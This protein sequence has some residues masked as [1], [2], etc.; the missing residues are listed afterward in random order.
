MTIPATQLARLTLGKTAATVAFRWIPFFLPTL[1]AAFDSSTAELTLILGLGEMGALVSLLAGRFFDRG[2]ERPIMCGGLT[3]TACSSAV[4]LG[5]SVTTFVVAFAMLIIGLSLYT[6]GG[7]T[8][9][10][11]RTPFD[12]RGRAIGLFETSWALALLLGAPIM[13]LLITR[14][15]W[16][17]PFVAIGLVAAVMVVVVTTTP[18]TAVVQPITGPT[19]STQRLSAATWRVI[20]ASAAI[21]I[22]GMSLIVVIGTWLDEALGVSTGGVGLAAMAFGAVELSSSLGS[23]ASSDRLGKTR[24]TRAMVL[25][26]LIGLMVISQAGSSLVV[27]LV[28]LLLFFSGF[29]YA[30]VTSFGLISE[31]MPSARGRA[32]ATGNAVGT[33]CRGSAAVLSGQLYERFDILGPLSLSAVGATMAFALLTAHDRSASGRAMAKQEQHARRRRDFLPG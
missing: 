30:L 13:A 2:Y 31:A 6:V 15:G 32:L 18:D 28:G 4:A 14:F 23:A 21:G 3:L 24:S 10:S 25:V 11:R 26:V 1:A 19:P 8:Y 12:Q 27:G 22:G 5:G 20:A 7:H 29:E 33:I 17:G 16:R 9:L